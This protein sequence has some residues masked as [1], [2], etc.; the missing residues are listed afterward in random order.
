MIEDP[1]DVSPTR[2]VPA[3]PR[4]GADEAKVSAIVEVLKNAKAPLVVVGK[5]AAYARAEGVI[6]RFIDQ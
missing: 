1:E 3:A 4:G 5:G 6:R 2:V